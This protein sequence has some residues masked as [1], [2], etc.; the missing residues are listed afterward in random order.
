M[1]LSVGD[2]VK[3]IDTGK[4]YTMITMVGYSGTVVEIRKVVT[5]LPWVLVRFTKYHPRFH[6]NKEREDENRY[7][8]FYED[9]LEVNK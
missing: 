2:R 5:G 7:Y 8:W 9:E 3:V 4:S 6:N 1:S